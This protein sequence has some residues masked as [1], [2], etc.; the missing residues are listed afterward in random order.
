MTALLADK[1]INSSRKKKGA[2]DFTRVN[3]RRTIANCFLRF[4]YIIFFEICISALLNVTVK[5]PDTSRIGILWASS[6]LII[7][8]IAFVILSVLSLLWKNGPYVED[9]YQ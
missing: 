4:V 7:I 3:Y 9:C 2:R 6:L 1:L 5:S 8:A